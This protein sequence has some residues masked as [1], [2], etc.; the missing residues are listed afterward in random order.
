M[1]RA[2]WLQV[3]EPRQA[4]HARQVFDGWITVEFLDQRVLQRCELFKRH[5]IDKPI[6]VPFAGRTFNFD[7]RRFPFPDRFNR[8]SVK[9]QRK[10]TDPCDILSFAARAVRCIDGDKHTS[11]TAL[12]IGQTVGMIRKRA[13]KHPRQSV[14]FPGRVVVKRLECE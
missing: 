6:C 10:R 9:V 3:P 5:V 11:A 12:Q 13:V 7:V 4:H 1:R 2:S 8:C 14:I